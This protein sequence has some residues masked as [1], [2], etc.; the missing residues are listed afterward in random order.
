MIKEIRVFSTPSCPWCLRL[1]NYLEEK[2]VD[3]E[4]IDVSQDQQAVTEMVTKSKQMGVPQI[5][6]DN[7]IIV[8]FDKDR[9]DQLL[10]IK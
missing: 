6:I 7:E 9:I 4:N 3:Y 5:W 1:K 2:N 10:D 8:G